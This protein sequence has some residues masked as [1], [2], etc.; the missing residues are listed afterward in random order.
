MSLLC[1]RKK[2]QGTPVVL[3]WVAPSRDST[4]SLTLTLCKLAF[5]IF[6]SHRRHWQQQQQP[7]TANAKNIFQCDLKSFP[8]C[9]TTVLAC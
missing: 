3:S 4:L 2:G 7:T 5:D 9:Q 8:D 1:E 6:T